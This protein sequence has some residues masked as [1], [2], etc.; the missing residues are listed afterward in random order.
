MKK[1]AFISNPINNTR[2][3]LSWCPEAPETKKYRDRYGPATVTTTP[4]IS[5]PSRGGR[6]Q[7][8]TVI[9]VLS[10]IGGS[11]VTVFGLIVTVAVAAMF[12]RGI[13]LGKMFGM[14]AAQFALLGV[15]VSFGGLFVI[16][17]W[18]LWKGAAW[19]WALEVVL[20]ILGLI[21]GMIT[22]PYLI[23]LIIMP[24]CGLILYYLPKPN[25]KAR[26]NKTVEV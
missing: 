9:S 19:A 20:V 15:I 23:G 17:G 24:V 14:F 5:K 22:I 18:G 21:I 25:V 26:F 7:G 13:G 10:L 8:V 12:S 16:V 3:W 11:I 1:D 2:K 6:P 4:P